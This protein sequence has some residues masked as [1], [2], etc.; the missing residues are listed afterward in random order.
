MINPG[1]KTN[2]LNELLQILSSESSQA[3]P[4]I[5]RTLLHRSMDPERNTALHAAPYQLTSAR[6]G[7]DN[8]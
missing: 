6:K 8:G 2:L 3:I 4:Q 1:P 5:I 7:Y